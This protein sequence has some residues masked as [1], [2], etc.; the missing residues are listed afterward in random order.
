MSRRVLIPALTMLALVA[1]SFGQQR[2]LRLLGNPKWLYTWLGVLRDVGGPLAAV[3]GGEGEFGFDVGNYYEGVIEARGRNLPLL[4]RTTGWNFFGVHWP[5]HETLLVEPLPGFLIYRNRANVA[6]RSPAGLVS[7]N[8]YGLVDREY[9]LKP[10]PG[11]N[12]IAIFGDSVTRGLGTATGDAMEAQ[13]EELLNRLPPG[14]GI[15]QTEIL[16]F[17]VSGYQLSQ[18]VAEVEEQ[19]PRFAPRVVLL[20]LSRQHM[21]PLSW[22]E[23]VSRLLHTGRDLR[24]PFLSEIAAQ[25]GLLP[26]DDPWTEGRAKLKPFFQQGFRHCLLELRRITERHNARLVV[27]LLPIVEKAPAVEEAVAGALRILDAEGFTVVNLLDTFH[28][29]GNLGSLRVTSRDPHPNRAGHRML[30]ENFLRKMFDDPLLF[31]LIAGRRPQARD[32]E[33]LLGSAQR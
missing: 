6:V 16:N 15:S 7:T 18:L 14:P 27:V 17:G 30:A 5:M 3:R 32:A 10:R 2:L 29:I 28:G 20:G 25:A 22:G 11:T 12:R 1:L 21:I 9:D 19:V 23:H 31:E 24:Y 33:L 13:L 8:A 4:L 26:T